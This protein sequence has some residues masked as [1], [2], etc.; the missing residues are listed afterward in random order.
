[1]LAN[2]S[3]WRLPWGARVDFYRFGALNRGRLGRC[4]QGELGGSASRAAGC[5]RVVREPQVIENCPGN[6]LLLVLIKGP[7]GAAH[8][9][10]PLAQPDHDDEQRLVVVYPAV[11]HRGTVCETPL[12]PAAPA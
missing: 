10:E 7:A 9:G 1:M 5:D 8:E 11:G 4:S 3:T 6:P 2:A 12:R